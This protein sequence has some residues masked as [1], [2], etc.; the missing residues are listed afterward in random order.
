MKH[1]ILLLPLILMLIIGKSLGQQDFREGFV[2]TLDGDTLSG[3]VEYRSNQKNY[4]SC[5]F[6]GEAGMVPYAPDQI[7]GFG[8]EGDK[9]FSAQVVDGVFVEVLITGP[10]SLYKLRDQYYVHKDTSLFALKSVLKQVERDGKVADVETS[11]WRGVLMLLTIDCLSEARQL[12]EDLTFREKSL[13]R[14]VIKYNRCQGADYAE[15]KADRPWT[16]VDWYVTSGM[17][18]SHIRMT[19]GELSLPHLRDTYHSLDP[20]VGVGFSLSSPRIWERGSLE[21]EVHYFRPIFS[22]LNEINRWHTEYYETIIDLQILSV[23]LSVKYKFPLKPFDVFLQGGMTFDLH[24]G[25]Y[26]L[27]RHELVMD[28]VVWT[29]PESQAFDLLPFDIFQLSG[30]GGIGVQKSFQRVK[31]GVTMRYYR[32]TPLGIWP[33]HRI[34]NHRLSVNFFISTP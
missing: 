14:L 16:E 22:S 20:F 30:W 31:A 10:I 19:S 27:V 7:L 24:L 11:N 12:V 8:Y 28:N 23:P 6:R 26:T 9:R 15:S 32:V 5:M 34:A 4:Q 13:T 2:I 21:G 29:S 25:S 18:G 1:P 33:L 3:W 17:V